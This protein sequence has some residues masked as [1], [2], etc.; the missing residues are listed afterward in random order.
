MKKIVFSM[1]LLSLSAATAFADVQRP[2]FPMP[3]PSG[4]I[5]LATCAVGLGAFA[6]RR[7]K[8]SL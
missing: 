2:R 4:M 6:L 7:R 3:E 1:F 8:T 5:E